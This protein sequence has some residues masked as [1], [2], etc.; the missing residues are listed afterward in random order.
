MSSKVINV[1]KH[2]YENSFTQ[3]SGPEGDTNKI[4]MTEGILQ[5][6]TMS[7]L[8]FNLYISEIENI[9]RTSD[10]PGVKI[11]HRFVLQILCYADDMV[12]L[13]SSPGGLQRKI[14]L[15]QEYFDKLGLKVNTSYDLSQSWSD[16]EN[17][18]HIQE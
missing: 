15:L 9:L 16:R 6:E 17:K 1:I 14:N 7:P 2:L 10:I 5:G 13:A 18:I 4:D 3:I 12:L 11:T 8:L